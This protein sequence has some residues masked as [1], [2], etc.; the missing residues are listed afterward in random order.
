MTEVKLSP[1]ERQLIDTIIEHV[2]PEP[3]TGRVLPVERD[4]VRAAKGLQR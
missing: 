3:E 1:R 4:E 2:Y